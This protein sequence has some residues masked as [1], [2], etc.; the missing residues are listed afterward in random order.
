MTIWYFY[1]NHKKKKTRRIIFSKYP[2][3]IR[4]D[5]LNDRTAQEAGVAYFIPI[6]RVIQIWFDG[7]DFSPLPINIIQ[8]VQSRNDQLFLTRIEVGSIQRTN[9]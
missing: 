2:Y 3:I 1:F 8:A 5:R 9:S 6:I 4:D 7:D